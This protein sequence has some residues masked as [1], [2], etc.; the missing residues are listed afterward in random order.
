MIER[1][2]IVGVGKGGVGKTTIAV[3]VAANWAAIHEEPILLVDCDTQA[4]ATRALGLHDEEKGGDLGLGLMNAV[5]HGDELHTV[6]N[7]KICGYA[8]L[9][10]IP[11]NWL[12][13]WLH[14]LGW[15]L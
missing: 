3:N 15:W 14:F 4:T 13:S 5:L 9:V 6:S 8:Q 2:I 12:V 10:C 7:R 11:V 1:S